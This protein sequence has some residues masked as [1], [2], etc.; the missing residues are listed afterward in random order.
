M[1]LQGTLDKIHNTVIITPGPGAIA[2]P[3]GVNTQSD[4]ALS[5]NV[6]IPLFSGGLVMAQTNQATYNFQVAEQQLEQVFRNTANITRQ[7]YLNVISGI[8]KISAD[9]LAIKSAVSSM[10]GLE[11]S[12]RVGTETLVNVLTQQQNVLQAQTQY[13]ADRYAYILNLLALKEAAGTLSFEDLRVINA[14]LGK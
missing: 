7:S 13:A 5:L 14:W 12:Y 3:S 4:K 6:T 1:T 10:T 2:D 9:K 11:E 8:P